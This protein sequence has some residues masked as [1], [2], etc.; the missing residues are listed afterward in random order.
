MAPPLP[1][2][3][4]IEVCG[5]GCH[6][7]LSMAAHLL[8]LLPS[9]PRPRGSPLSSWFLDCRDAQRGPSAWC[10]SRRWVGTAIVACSRSTSLRGGL[11]GSWGLRA[12]CQRCRL[13]KWRCR[14]SKCSLSLSWRRRRWRER[15]SEGK[16]PSRLSLSWRG[17]GRKDQAR[18]C[19]ASGPSSG[20]TPGITPGGRSSLGGL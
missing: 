8:P 5:T 17:R 13:S 6:C 14:F 15:G 3:R 18:N 9:S 12:I 7:R 11:G 16:R 1:V 2:H 10:R 19:T 4:E 20:H